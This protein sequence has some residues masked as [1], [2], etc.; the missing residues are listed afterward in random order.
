[1]IKSIFYLISVSLLFSFSLS[2][3][4][5]TRIVEE[6]S[7]M[8]TKAIFLGKSV[9]V[10]EAISKSTTSAERKSLRKIAK[11]VP[12][13]FKGRKNR[14]SAV[15]QSKEHQGPDRVLQKVNSITGDNQFQICVNRQGWE[16]SSPSDPTGDV[17]RDYYLQA[18]NVTSVA[19]FDRQGMLIETFNMNTL[20][21][22][23]GASSEGD[24]IILFDENHDRWI[25][26]EFTDPANLLIGVSETD[27][28]LGSYFVYNFS[29]PDF[30]DYP[31][32]ALTPDALVVTTNEEGAGTLHQYFINKEELFAGETDA[33]IQRVGIPGTTETEGGFFVSTP[34]DFNGSNEPFDNNP[35]VL[36]L[37]DS[38]WAGGPTEDGIELYSFNVDFD[39]VNNTV[40]E[41][42]EIQISPYDAFPCSLNSPGFAC[43]PQLGGDGLD[44][45]P[46]TI[47]NIPHHRNF[48]THESIVF[49]FIT[50][51]TDGE[52]VSGVRWVE[53]RRTVGSDWSLYQEGTVGSDDGLHRYMSTIA[54]DERGGICLGY[55]VSGENSYVDMRITGRDATDSLGHMT[56]EETTIQEGLNTIQS[57]SAGR[58]GDYAQMSVA[59][60]NIGEFWY[61]GEYA[62]PN[63]TLTNI[64]AIKLTP[65]TFDLTASRFITPLSLM[66]NLSTQEAV[67]IEVLNSG[68][69][70]IS[71]F[72]LELE[73]D[74]IIVSSSTIQDTLANGETMLHTF[75]DSVDLSV[76]GN[77]TFR[78]F[79]TQALDSYALND[80][81]VSTIQ[82]LPS[83]DGSITAEANQNSCQGMIEGSI[84][85]Q[86]LGGSEI[87]SAVIAASLNGD[88]QPDI[89]FAGAIST[90]ITEAIP[91]SIAVPSTGIN[92][93]DF[94]ILSINGDMDFDSANNTFSVEAN[95]LP[96]ENA[97]TISLLTDAFPEETS[98]VLSSQSTGEIIAEL[99]NLQV[100]QA[101]SI[102]NT[103]VCLDLDDCYI[104]TLIDTYGDG[105]CC[106]EGNGNITITNN[107][108]EEIFFFNGEFGTE[109]DLEFCAKQCNLSAIID[110]TASETSTNG[111]GIIM[112]TAMGGT[113]PYSYSIDGGSTF[114]DDNIFMNLDP[115][116]YN[117]V[118]RD[119]DG[120]CIYEETVEVQL[121]TSI[122]EIQ[123]ASVT[124]NISPNPTAGVFK[125]S[126]EGLPTQDDQLKVY[127]FN[128]DGKL[129]QQRTVG[130]FDNNFIGTFSIYGY[131][132]GTYLVRLETSELNIMERVIRQ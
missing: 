99:G 111:E 100:E 48:E 62:G 32:Y 107:E 57:F 14:S 2:A 130:K 18:V 95:I 35:I 122:Y 13:N 4:I 27:D 96:I 30:P 94:E 58:F 51:I 43:V 40:I 29:T 76:V 80:T 108:G 84:F 16:Q 46:E 5:S 104:L 19:V 98:Y 1:M 73:L 93:V 105:I 24:P 31:K 83:L 50:D 68:K 116:V 21:A 66:S 90:L 52:N 132:A 8:E 37:D 115:G 6:A 56:Y 106:Y 33:R 85:L 23:F 114:S 12:D 87:T 118:V 75:P 120:T 124:V 11:K 59:P 129:L 20:W 69:D 22:Q 101:S 38:S 117:V 7:I 125:I 34:V 79:V 82:V 47:M 3:Q 113:E 127:L 91:F 15:K 119:I 28:P 77:Y 109:I 26:S 121:L 64:A 45:L 42:T 41:Q 97:F 17:S 10:K 70:T 128:I 63:N 102:I 89:T 44:G 60:E 110:V 88:V 61:T 67:T 71:D 53:L 112:I 74:G 55:S 49:T 9:A 123:G 36:R 103:S 54:M 25:L 126:I 39:D 65:D 78:S 72:L 81:I 92:T 86:N 131:P